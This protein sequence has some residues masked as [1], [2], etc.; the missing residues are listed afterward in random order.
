MRAHIGGGI[1]SSERNAIFEWA[2]AGRLR[3]ACVPDALRLAGVTPDRAQWQ[4]F[5]EA[6]LLGLGALLLAAGAIYFVAF[7]WQSLGRFGKFALVEI[8]IVVAIG[9]CGWRGLDTIVGKA[10]LVAAALLVGALLALTGQV[11][12]TG[13]DTFELF[14]AWALGIAVWVA[15][16]R[17]AALWLLW[18]A[19]VNL[20]VAFY[21][22]AFPGIFWIAFG[23]RET[24]WTLFAF[25]TVVLVAWEGLAA[26]GVVWLRERWAARSIALVSGAAI[27]LLAVWSVIGSFRSDSWPIPAYLAWLGG[28]YF[29]YRRRHPDLFVLAAAVLS[30]IAVITAAVAYRVAT[31]GDAGGFLVVGMVIVGM[32]S[33]GAWWL[34]RISAEER[35]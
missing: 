6:L 23:P 17:L 27:T 10:A 14:A 30:V 15:A 12:Q 16:S 1:M 3:P 9:L 11:Y 13:A 5:I 24:L 33:A 29:A 4:R 2:A 32:G 21:F 31:R 28:V 34:R 18:L 25:N 35:P 7:N 8:P 26:F 20:A 22:S 19:I